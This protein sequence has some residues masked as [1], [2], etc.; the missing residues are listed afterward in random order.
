MGGRLSLKGQSTIENLPCATGVD[1]SETRIRCALFWH[2]VSFES[3]PSIQFSC[4]LQVFFF[5]SFQPSRKRYTRYTK[6]KKR[7]PPRATM[8]PLAC[9]LIINIRGDSTAHRS[10]T[11][12]KVKRLL[13]A[14]TFTFSILLPLHWKS[15]RE[16]K[17]TRRETRRS[18]R[19]IAKTSPRDGRRRSPQ[20]LAKE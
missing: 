17:P 15:R 4:W 3:R 14:H 16:G 12:R 20:R 7:A 9:P 13:S 5:L 19:G 1:R 11:R 18:P 10:P 8:L 6:R 2:L